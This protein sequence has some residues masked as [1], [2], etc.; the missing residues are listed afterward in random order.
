MSS[1]Q[2]AKL[3][4]IHKGKVLTEEHK[5]KMSEAQKRAWINR[6]LKATKK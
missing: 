6:K 4:A 2:K 5:Q 1:E 3:S